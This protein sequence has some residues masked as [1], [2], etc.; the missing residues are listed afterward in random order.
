MKRPS[1]VR[2]F[3]VDETQLAQY[4]ELAAENGRREGIL[5][6]RARERADTL[7]SLAESAR[8][9]AELPGK[10]HEMVARMLDT[11]IGFIKAGGHVR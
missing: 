3:P 8:R 1:N 11:L 7:H 2:L 6:G 10:D 9:F 5:I 4:L